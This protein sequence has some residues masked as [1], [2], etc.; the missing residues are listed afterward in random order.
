MRTII[1]LA[2]RTPHEW[3]ALHDDGD[4]FRL[5]IGEAA[6]DPEAEIHLPYGAPGF[7]I[8]DTLYFEIKSYLIRSGWLEGVEDDS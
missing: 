5:S 4:G 6:G 8:L 7:E 3:I 1:K 2:A